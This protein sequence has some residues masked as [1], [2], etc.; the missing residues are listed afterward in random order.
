VSSSFV[1]LIDCL[2]TP[3]VLKISAAFMVLI[4]WLDWWTSWETSLFVFYAGPISLIAWRVHRQAGIA[5]GVISGFVWLFANWNTHPY[6]SLFAYL[7]A[8]ANR[9]IYFVFV[10][11]GVAAFRSLRQE[12]EAKL[13][14]L[15][16]A[17]NLE[18]LVTFSGEREQMRIGRDLHDG[19]CQSLAAIDCATEYLRSEL[20]KEGLAQAHVAEAIQKMVRN[21]IHEAK[22]LARG[23]FPV[24]LDQ[25]GLETALHDVT[26]SMADLYGIPVDVQIEGDISELS[27]EKA[28]HVY[29][30]AQ[31]AVS[32]A[33]RHANPSQ[34]HLH[35]T[36]QE[37]SMLVLRVTDDGT[38]FSSADHDSAG[39]G[40]QSMRH[41]AQILGGTLT[42]RPGAESG[43]QIEC[44][45]PL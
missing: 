24:K 30:I 31:E 5:L 25:Q 17:R 15:L 35:L 12:S 38:G 37:N 32:N 10:A 20:R 21:T 9:T 42:I 22:T 18:R 19:V 34:V 41:R 39:V 13:E 40:I 45:F 43:T 7:W 36:L 4:G 16:A 33:L 11:V 14:A 44:I 23:L 6:Q 3:T 2:E 8:S 29:R 1:R 27:S 26:T 28:I